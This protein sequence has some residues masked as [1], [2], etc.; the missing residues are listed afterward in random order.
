M[1]SQTKAGKVYLRPH[2]AGKKWK[3]V[4]LSL[5]P[6]SSSGVG[7][8]EIQDIGGGAAGGDHGAVWRHHQPLGDRRVKVVRLSELISVL[9]LPP[10]AEACPLEN[11]SAFCVETQDRTMV[12]AAL[13]DECVDWV[14]KLCK[15]CFQR[16][17][18]SGPD[19][20]LMEENQ[21]YASADEAPLFWVLAQ[22]TDAATRCGLQGSFWLQVGP[23]ALLLRDPQK[24]NIV[25]EWPYKLLRRYGRDKLT[26]TIEAGRRCGSGPG[27]FSFETQQAEQVF[28]LIQSSIK[29]KTSSATPG[30]QTQEAETVPVTN[31][32]AHSPLP[33]IPDVTSAAAMLDSKLRRRDRSPGPEDGS[34]AESVGQSDSAPAPI[35]LMPLPLLPTHGRTSGEHHGST[36]D[37]IYADPSDCVPSVLKARPT[38]ALYVDPANVLPLKPPGSKESEPPRPAS[39]APRPGPTAEVLDS[40]YSDVFDK[41][42]PDQNNQP[43]LPS[44]GEAE[45]S[46]EPIYTEPM[47]KTDSEGGESK[48]DPFAHLYAQVCRKV[49]SPVPSVSVTPPTSASSSSVRLGLTR[50]DARDQTLDDDVIYENLGII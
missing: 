8:L 19:Q 24:K 28:S 5:F 47:S 29:Q 34:P 15:S 32:R 11:T 50:T 42:S 12:F 6:H 22:R 48:P 49:P 3:P 18:G 25:R 46:A 43:V 31:I 30:H 1:D 37:A 26:L 45:S 36:P 27:T 16:G 35:T 7:R 41:I 33:K 39:S 14:E 4:W 20:L 13:K 2:K 10:N 23:E 17:G 9:R 40:V 44:A 38:T 21:I